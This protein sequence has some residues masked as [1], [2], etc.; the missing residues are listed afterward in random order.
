MLPENS[1]SHE[2]CALL[3]HG[4]ELGHGLSESLNILLARSTEPVEAQ[5]WDSVGDI[6]PHRSTMG[7][8]S[9]GI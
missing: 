5:C 4:S 7:H 6:G 1:H 3:F 9:Q 8:I 2:T